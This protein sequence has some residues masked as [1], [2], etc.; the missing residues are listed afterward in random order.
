ME[1][2]KRRLAG[3]GARAS[4]ASGDE[5]ERRDRPAGLDELS[6]KELYERARDLDISGRSSMDQE[7]L[8]RAILRSA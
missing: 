4:P 7:E 1:V 3:A 2:L 8:I 5:A 6:K